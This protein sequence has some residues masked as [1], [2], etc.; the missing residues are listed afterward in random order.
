MA[1]TADRTASLEGEEAVR[2]EAFVKQLVEN[3][4]KLLALDFDLTLVSMHTGGR[5][6]GSAETLARSVRPIFRTI[7]PLCQSAGIEVSIVTMSQQTRLIANVLRLSL[8]C[9][10]TR[11]RIRGGEKQK[12]VT[13]SGAVES[14][15]EIAGCRK[16]KHISSLLQ[17]RIEHG[18]SALLPHQVLLIDD[19]SMNVQEALDHENRALLFNPDAPMM[20]IVGV[21]PAS[22]FD[23]DDVV[24][25]G[26]E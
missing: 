8:Q 25:H 17:C 20:L 6:W 19:D 10:T 24:T 9:D 21:D 18:E 15:S 11:I 22:S 26:H 23:M 12:L 14:V 16:Q 3:N 13:E 5:W 4:V 7:I 2:A 1:D